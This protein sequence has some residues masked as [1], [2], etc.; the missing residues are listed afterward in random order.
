MTAEQMEKAYPVKGAPKFLRDLFT[1]RGGETWAIGRVYSLPVLLA[2]VGVPFTMIIRGQDVDLMG[3]G[4]MF[5][6]LA[7]GIGVLVK[8]TSDVDAPPTDV[9]GE[10]HGRE[11]PPRRRSRGQGG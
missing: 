11:G 5:G 2:G 6:G 4:A 9:A 8:M 7:A 3:L 10:D 1:D